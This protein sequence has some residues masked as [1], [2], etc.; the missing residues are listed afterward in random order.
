MILGETVRKMH[1]KNK[2][3]R[4][5]EVSRKN[6]ASSFYYLAIQNFAKYYRANLWLVFFLPE[7]NE[8]RA[9]YRPTSG[10]DCEVSVSI[11]AAIPQ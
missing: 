1:T 7:L 5:I 6:F 11:A 8:G 9:A 10:R 4:S 2:V 3:K